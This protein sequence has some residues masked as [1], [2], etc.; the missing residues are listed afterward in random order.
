MPKQDDSHVRPPASVWAAP[1]VRTFMKAGW[2]QFLKPTRLPDGRAW[3]AV[4]ESYDQ[5]NDEA[6]YYVTLTEEG[7]DPAG[8]F[9]RVMAPPEGEGSKGAALRGLLREE[10][11]RAAEAGRANTDYSGSLVGSQ[12]AEWLKAR[13][14]QSRE[15]ELI[16]A[17]GDAQAEPAGR[18][19]LSAN[20]RLSFEMESRPAESIFP[21]LSFLEERFG[22][23][24]GFPIFGLDAVYTEG[25]AGAV[26]IVVGYDNWSGCFIQSFDEA[27]DRLVRTMGEAVNSGEDRRESPPVKPVMVKT[28]APSRAAAPPEIV[29][30]KTF[31]AGASLPTEAEFDEA[32]AALSAAAASADSSNT[33]RKASEE[34]GF[35]ETEFEAAARRLIQNR[36]RPALRRH[37][38][39]ISSRRLELLLNAIVDLQPAVQAYRARLLSACGDYDNEFSPLA[40]DVAGLT[41]EVATA[42]AAEPSGKILLSSLP[43]GLLDASVRLYMVGVDGRLDTDSRSFRQRLAARD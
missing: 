37:P 31:P 11:H 6:Y 30:F 19:F 14:R 36:I 24:T 21:L 7:R 39:W 27:G 23:K 13:R 41:A 2:P 3:T 17:P 1:Q 43:P 5:R 18:F 40:A 15:P 34:A 33:C 12:A 42:Y 28:P 26:K 32:L 10:I 20:G 22:L 16:P 38:E 8:F 29:G 35:E 4:F 9:V 25:S